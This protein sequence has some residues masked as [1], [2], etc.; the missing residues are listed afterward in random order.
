[1]KNTTKK[2]ISA[3]LIVFSILSLTACGVDM[4]KLSGTW[5]LS[6]IDGKSV[7]D[8]AAEGG[9]A[10]VTLQKVVTITEKDF[11]FSY[12]DINGN[13]YT[14][15]GT[16]E[17]KSNGIDVK[18]T[19]GTMLAKDSM[20]SVLFDEK[21][22][23]ICIVM[24]D[25]VADRK[26]IFK[27]GSY[28]LKA[29]YNEAFAAQAPVESQPAAETGAEYQEEAEYQN[30]ADYQ[31]EEALL[32]AQAEAEAQAQA[33]AEAAAQAQAEA[34]EDAL[35]EVAANAMVEGMVD[36][37][38]EGMVEGIVEEAVEAAAEG[39][40]DYGYEDYSDSDWE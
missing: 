20:L 4:N 21:E 38:V 39:Y 13:I 6:T 29:K 15:K 22:S 2:I 34:E 35:A 40:D 25:G 24:N 5:V 11:A 32:A 1:M 33:E 14:D 31:D 19:E 30:E 37:M 12:I 8:V 7:A 17:V 10:E 36:G 3:L 18:I 26:M 28:D 9:Y 16:N 23:T 27:K